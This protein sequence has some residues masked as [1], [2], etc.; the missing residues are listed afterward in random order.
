[1]PETVAYGEL[2]AANVSNDTVARVRNLTRLDGNGPVFRLASLTIDVTVTGEGDG[3][4]PEIII[5]G[6]DPPPSGVQPDRFE[7]LA[8]SEPMDAGTW[9]ASLDAAQLRQY[10][11]VRVAYRHLVHVLDD[12]RYRDYPTGDGLL[13]VIDGPNDP[14]RAVRHVSVIAT[15]ELA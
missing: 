11:R 13:A 6:A 15:G 2:F 10:V 5:E 8:A 14:A 4:L 1:M 7:T 12:P 9:S 3:E